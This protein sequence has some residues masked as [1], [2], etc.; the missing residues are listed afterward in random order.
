M[1]CAWTINIRENQ[2]RIRLD[3]WGQVINITWTCRNKILKSQSSKQDASAKIYQSIEKYSFNREGKGKGE[4]VRCS[5]ERKSSCWMILKRSN[6][7]VTFLL[8]SLQLWS[9]TVNIS[10]K[11]KNI[12]FEWKLNSLDIRVLHVNNGLW[13]S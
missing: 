2:A 11:K 9:I 3:Y 5:V 13:I 1:N 4:L 10:D 6:F 8:W 7:A 12:N